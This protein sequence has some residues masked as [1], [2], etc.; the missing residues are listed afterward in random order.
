[1]FSLKS[2]VSHGNVSMNCRVEAATKKQFKLSDKQYKKV[3]G[4]WSSNSSGGWDIKF[5][6]SKVKYYDRT[7]GDLAWTAAIKGCKKKDGIYVYYIKSEKGCYEF[8]TT[9]FDSGVLE[10]YGSWD[11]EHYVDYY[12]GSASL[13][14]GKWGQL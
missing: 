14:C 11:D 13:S 1:M 2:L 3:K 10:Y 5:T 4:W 6:R 12:S 9:K 8:R 7:T